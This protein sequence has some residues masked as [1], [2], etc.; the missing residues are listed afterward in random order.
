MP[1]YSRWKHTRSGLTNL[2]GTPTTTPT[3]L[4]RYLAPRYQVQPLLRLSYAIHCR[5]AA[6]LDRRRRW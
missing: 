5:V 4:H 2:S 6:L 3:T 1:T